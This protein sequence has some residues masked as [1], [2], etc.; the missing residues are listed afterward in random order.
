MRFTL[1]T[2]SEQLAP[3]ATAL[4]ESLLGA[5]HVVTVSRPATAGRLRRR[6]LEPVEHPLTDAA[7]STRAPEV[8]WPVVSTLV[9]EA[10]RI[11]TRIDSWVARRPDWPEPD[12]DLIRAVPASPGLSV[13]V[14][15]PVPERRPWEEHAGT[16]AEGRHS[17]RTVVLAFRSTPAGPGHMLRRAMLRA[18]IQVRMVERVDLDVQAD[19]DLVVIVESPTPPIEV[20]GSSGVPVV[21]W[22]HH[23]EHHL[24]GNLRLERR[25]RPDLVLMAHS[26]HLAARFATRV[27]RF[28][29]AVAPELA[30]DPSWSGRDLDLAFVGRLGGAAY[31]RREHLIAQARAGLDRV[32]AVGGIDLIEM[33]ALYRRARTVLNEGGTRHLPITMR[34]FEAIGAGA[35][36]VTDRAPGLE[37]LF[38]GG[39]LPI[40]AGGLPIE[41]IVESLR[42][43]EAE[44]LARAAHT[45][46]MRQHTYDH[47]VDL[48][49]RMVDSLTSRAH[50]TS[51]QPQTPEAVFLARH[52][53]AQRILDASGRIVE[54]GREIWRPHDL[55]DDPRPGS[56][57][58]VAMTARSDRG[59]ARAARRYVIGWGL[60]PDALGLRY[61]SVRSIEDL[62]VVDLGAEAYDVAT[63]GGPSAL[64]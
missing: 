18:G 19:A 13:P 35:L 45:H 3:R 33:M 64:E 21:F 62:V 2:R 23:G 52:P 38:D 30:F 36:L 28:P 58:I 47:R 1:L 60:D 39:Y 32:E 54:P 24:E 57:D 46:A 25:Y 53:Y 16:T 63:V 10:D 6:S 17:G 48:L 8:I 11:A 51:E 5:G 15:A 7:G 55:G 22:V 49:L 20:T 29:F 12:R 27:E 31:E 4:L 37:E 42:S 34:V 50:R 59:L 44:R 43:G 61:R 26:W 9:D 56:F 14:S 41:R 40:G